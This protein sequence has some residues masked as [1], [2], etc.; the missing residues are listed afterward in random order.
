MRVACVQ[1]LST[2]CLCKSSLVTA[3]HLRLHAV[4]IRAR[5]PNDDVNGM[6][7]GR[8]ASDRQMLLGQV[9]NDTLMSGVVTL[10]AVFQP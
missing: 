5:N 1:W 8:I 4:T 10:L 6:V 7:F 3:C 2:A 9:N